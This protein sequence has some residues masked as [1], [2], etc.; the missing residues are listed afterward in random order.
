MVSKAILL[1]LAIFHPP[2]NR[3]GVRN[4]GGDAVRAKGWPSLSCLNDVPISN[5]FSILKQNISS[6]CTTVAF[7][8]YDDNR[9]LL[10]LKQPCKSC[11]T[12]VLFTILSS[13]AYLVPLFEISFNQ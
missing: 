11:N 5:A 13:S 2:H 6:L 3:S 9:T 1:H 4:G 7:Y 10:M 8:T 12:I